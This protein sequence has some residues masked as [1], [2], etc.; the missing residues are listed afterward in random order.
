[1]AMKNHK[2]QMTQLRA[3]IFDAKVTQAQLASEAGVT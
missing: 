3:A 2:K 1:M